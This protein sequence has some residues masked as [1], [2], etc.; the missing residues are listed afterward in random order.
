[1]HNCRDREKRLA[2]KSKLQYRKSSAHILSD[3]SAIYII[4][5]QSSLVIKE[6]QTL[7]GSDSKHKQVV[8]N[9]IQARFW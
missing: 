3:P 5:K 6:D 9:S 8:S 1:M 4:E 2:N 7:L